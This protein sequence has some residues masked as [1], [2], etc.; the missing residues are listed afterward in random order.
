M[1][2]KINFEKLYCGSLSEISKPGG[3]VFWHLTWKSDNRTVT[4]YIRLEE[5]AEIRRGIKAYQKAKADLQKAASVNLTR[6][7]GGRKNDR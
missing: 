3:K 5:V 4:R 2:P 7:M 1:N 6:L